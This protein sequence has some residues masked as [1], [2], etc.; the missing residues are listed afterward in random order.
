M[1]SDIVNFYNRYVY[2]GS[3]TFPPCEQYVYWNVIATVLPIEIH[4]YAKFKAIMNG[5]NEELGRN[6]NNRALQRIKSHG[7]RF[8]GALKGVVTST[9]FLMAISLLIL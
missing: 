2:L 3:E 5:K 8:I 6:G 4:T 1:D 9:I 7:I